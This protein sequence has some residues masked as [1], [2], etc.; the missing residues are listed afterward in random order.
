VV[1]SHTRLSTGH[2]SSSPPGKGDHHRTTCRAGSCI[3][4]AGS[5]QTPRPRSAEDPTGLLRENF[6]R[7]RPSPPWSCHKKEK[8]QRRSQIRR[9]QKVVRPDNDSFPDE[10]TLSSGRTTRGKKMKPKRNFRV[11]PSYSAGGPGTKISPSV[12]GC[13]GASPMSGDSVPVIR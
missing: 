3:L 5:Q 7:L 4:P 2:P 12:R 1:L 13:G 10:V 8:H 9:T 6:F 11:P